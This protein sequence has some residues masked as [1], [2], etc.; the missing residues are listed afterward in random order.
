MD[1]NHTIDPKYIAKLPKT[2]PLFVAE[3]N[4]ALEKLENPKLMRELG[5][6]LANVD[7]FDKPGVMRSVPY[8]LGL[9]KTI[10]TEL[11]PSKGGKGEFELDYDFANALGWSGDGSV[12]SGSLKEFAIGAVVQHFTKTLKRTPITEVEPGWRFPFARR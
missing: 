9:S 1:N 8:T 6:I 10:T 2:D 4:P 12:G 5:L 11:P 7:G 3:T